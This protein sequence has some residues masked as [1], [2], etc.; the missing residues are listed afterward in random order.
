MSKKWEILAIATIFQHNVHIEINFFFVAMTNLPYNIHFHYHMNARANVCCSYEW[1]LKPG[2]F[3]PES[4]YFIPLFNKISWLCRQHGQEGTKCRM[5][6]ATQAQQD[7]NLRITLIIKEKF[8]LQIINQ[9]F[10]FSNTQ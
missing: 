5:R 3:N 4:Q 8:S 10:H 7:M 6:G 2:T 1:V 9:V